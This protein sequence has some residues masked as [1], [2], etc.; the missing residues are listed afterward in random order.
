MLNREISSERPDFNQ[1]Q[2]LNSIPVRE[3]SLNNMN[4]LVLDQFSPNFKE[5]L[6]SPYEVFTCEIS[7]HISTL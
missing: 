2:D 3:I 5:L 4:R 6:L 1:G 7:V